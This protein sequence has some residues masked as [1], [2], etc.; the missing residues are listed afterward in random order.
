[1]YT[2]FS[3][4]NLL[5]TAVEV[6]SGYTG[7]DHAYAADAV[8][9]RGSPGIISVARLVCKIGLLLKEFKLSFHV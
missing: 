1:M 3:V 4:C 5:D 2:G 7:S 9:L 8:T 6:L